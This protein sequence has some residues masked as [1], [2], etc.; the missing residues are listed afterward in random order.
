MVPGLAFIVIFH[1]M[2][3]FSSGVPIL[4]FWILKTRSFVTSSCGISPSLFHSELQN[5]FKTS[6]SLNCLKDAEECKIFATFIANT[7]ESYIVCTNCF[8]NC[9][10]KI[11]RINYC[12]VATKRETGQCLWKPGIFPIY[13]YFCNEYRLAVRKTMCLELC[14]VLKTISVTISMIILYLRF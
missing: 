7:N 6:K 2:G 14:S 4:P 5:R 8:L 1:R 9:K 3:I 10:N 13:F 11:N 12:R